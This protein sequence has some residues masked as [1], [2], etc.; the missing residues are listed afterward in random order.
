MDVFRELYSSATLQVRV[1]NLTNP[2][3]IQRRGGQG[4]TIS[5]NLFTAGHDDVVKSLKLDNCGININSTD[6]SH[7]RFAGVLFAESLYNLKRMLKQLYDVS[8]RV[9]VRMNER[10]LQ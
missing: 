5:P 3:P 1:H 10:S 7:L 8:L 9:D 4:D 6:L 2:V